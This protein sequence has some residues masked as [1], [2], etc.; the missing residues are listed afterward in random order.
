MH[1]FECY[2]RLVV[3]DNLTQVKTQIRASNQYEAE[4]LLKALYGEDCILGLLRLD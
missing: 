3:N 4:Q 2:L 1:T